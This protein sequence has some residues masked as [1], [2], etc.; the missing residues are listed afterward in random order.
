MDASNLNMIAGRSNGFRH[1]HLNQN[2]ETERCIG[3][4]VARLNLFLVIVPPVKE[5][6]DYMGIV[7]ICVENGVRSF[8]LI[9]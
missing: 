7:Q 2:E 8:Q 9:R 6:F 1:Y 5:R 3:T 4:K